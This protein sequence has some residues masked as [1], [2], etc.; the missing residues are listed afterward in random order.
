MNRSNL[1]KV[2]VVF[3]AGVMVTM[4]SLIYWSTWKVNQLRKAAESAPVARTVVFLNAAVGVS[5]HGKASAKSSK[6]PGAGMQGSRAPTNPGQNTKTE[7]GNPVRV[8]VPQPEVPSSV[9]RETAPPDLSGSATPENIQST[10]VIDPPADGVA[11]TLEIPLDLQATRTQEATQPRRIS[12]TVTLESGANL[13]IRLGQSLSADRSHVGDAFRGTL[14]S[15]LIVNGAVLADKGSS[16]RGEVVRAKRARLLRAKSDLGLILTE[17]SL[18]DGRRARIETN[19]WEEKGERKSIEDTPR[20]AAEAALGAVVGAF[21]G[22]ARGAG[23]VSRDGGTG[24]DRVTG[25]DKRTVIL[26]VGS[27]L[28]FQLTAPVTITE[29][30]TYR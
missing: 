23:L 22:A 7:E 14:D 24:K 16:V 20:M 21:H 30:V 4:G 12:R 25:V 27:R 6:N 18:G 8:Q 29:R 2:I 26:P 9:T 11:P 19:L 13:S 5:S 28:T 15:P 1:M 17:I 3:V 10:G